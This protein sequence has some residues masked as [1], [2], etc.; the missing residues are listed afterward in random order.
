M[1]PAIFD[2]EAT[3]LPL[4]SSNQKAALNGAFGQLL[5]WCPGVSRAHFLASWGCHSG[6]CLSPNQQP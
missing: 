1:D 3:I 6:P 2:Q 4:R 5:A